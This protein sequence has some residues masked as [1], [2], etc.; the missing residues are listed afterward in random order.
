MKIHDVYVV[1]AL[2]IIFTVALDA[3]WKMVFQ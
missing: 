2:A 1:F 3:I